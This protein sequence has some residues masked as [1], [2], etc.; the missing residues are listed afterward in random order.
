MVWLPF[1]VCS[2]LVNRDIRQR[3]YFRLVDV[4]YDSDSGEG[5][6]VGSEFHLERYEA[7]IAASDLVEDH[8]YWKSLR[9]CRGV[10]ACHNGIS[11]VIDRM[12]W[13]LLYI[14]HR[15]VSSFPHQSADKGGSFQ[16]Y[17]EQL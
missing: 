6:E 17:G 9:K 1:F 2:S 3:I 11:D 7:V 14:S 10:S 5:L 13:N 4:L 12:A 16:F 15:R 8:T